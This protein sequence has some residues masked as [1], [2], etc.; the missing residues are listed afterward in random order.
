MMVDADVAYVSPSSVY[1]IL[2]EKDL[3]CR[4]KPPQRG[5]EKMAEPSAPHHQWHTDLMNLWVNGR[6]YFFIGVLDSFSRYIVHWDLL[7][8]MRAGGV[9]DVVHAAL[10]KYPG[11]QPRI[12]HDNGSQFTGKDFRAL[13]KRFS[14]KQIRTR[15]AHPE[16][17]G[18]IERF[19]RSLRQEGLSAR[20]Y[21]N[22]YDARQ[23]IGEWIEEYN[24]RRLHAGLQYLTPNDWMQQRQDTRLSERRTKLSTARQQRYRENLKCRIERMKCQR[25]NG[26]F[27]P[28]PPGFSAFRESGLLS[29]SEATGPEARRQCPTVN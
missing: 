3:L 18:R 4:W 26:G 15:V 9:V 1:R 16:S 20:D 5:G 17:N 2:D 12:V 23:V 11:C 28:K 25:T 7:T 22:L 29:S 14:L 8:D 6:W 10:D 27:A 24:H 13:L 21:Q 19:H